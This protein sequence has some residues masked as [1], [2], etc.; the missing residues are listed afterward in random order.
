[1]PEV[2][3]LARDGSMHHARPLAEHFQARCVVEKDWRPSAILAHDPEIVITFDEHHC[4]LGLCIAEMARQ[5]ITNLQIMDGILE[6]RRTWAYPTNEVKRPINQPVLSHKVA[7]LGRADA[8]IM[9]SWGNVGKCE[10]I[11]AP[12]LDRL[13]EN[14]KPIR[15][16][17]AEQRPLHLLIATAKVPGFTPEQME[18]TYRSLSDLKEF[19]AGRSDIEVI[20][21]VT[22]NL[23]QRLRV[24]N[25]LKDVLSNELHDILA[26]IDA[27]ITTPSNIML[28]SMLFGLPV[29]LLDYH[30]CPHYI[31][32]AWRITAQEQIAP[33]VQELIE[34]PLDR[35]LYQQFC[36]EDALSCQSAAL[37][38]MV[39]LIEEMLR[40]RREC[41]AHG[42]KEL[43]FPHRILNQPEDYVSWP[44]EG[45]D[46]EKLYPGHPV[47]GER[48]LAYMQAEL[49]SALGTIDL[50]KSQV[51][52][53]TAR[54]H[55]LP[56]YLWVKKLMN[57]L[58]HRP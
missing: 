15:S 13:V 5:N 27:V 34:A 10:V 47:F 36:L 9:E 52:T 35:M 20:W 43:A 54:L 51:D 55:R 37:P 23:H 56:G 58:K 44:A 16:K 12:R 26:N 41:L 24:E 14:R 57:W 30:N 18:T 6:W 7:C 22:Q 17:F 3:I 11:G 53:L 42:E 21:R 19:L 49:E 2:V 29:A 38:R 33:V 8:R 39:K 4:E 48:R 28:E 50:L 40:I 31:P 46:L 1:M 32:A 25:T 45:F